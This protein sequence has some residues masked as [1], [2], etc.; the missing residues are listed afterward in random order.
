MNL[1]KMLRVMCLITFFF[2]AIAPANAQK[3]FEDL[4]TAGIE[5]HDAGKYEEAI[6]KFEAALKIDPQN[7]FAHYEMANTYIK[8]RWKNGRIG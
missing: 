1:V 3:N 6:Q 7:T 2:W 5:L 4:M 8:S